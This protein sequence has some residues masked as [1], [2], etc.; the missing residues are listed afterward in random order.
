MAA[1]FE[2]QLDSLGTCNSAIKRPKEIAYF[3]YDEKHQFRLDASSI[4]YY[5]PPPLG[6]D[7][8]KGFP[9][10]EKLDDTADDHLDSLLKTIA[11]HEQEIGSKIAA[12]VITWRGLMTKIMAVPYS[13]DSFEL[14]ATIFE[15]TIFI[16]EN[17]DYK[18]ASWEKQRQQR[19]RPGQPSQDVMSFWGYKFETLCLLPDTWDTVSRDFIENRENH[20][21]NNYAQ[22]CSVV[23]TSIGS[24]SMVIG[25]EV[26]AVWDKKPEDTNQ[27]IKWVELKTS[28]EIQSDR[29]SLAFE[30]K[31]M[32]FWIQ[33]FL[34]GVPKIIVGFRSRKGILQRIEE[35]DTASIPGNV[36]RS[37]RA[38]WDGKLC[39]NFAASFLDFLKNTITGGVWRIRRQENSTAVEVFRI[40]ET[41]YS[42]IISDEFL[43]WRSELAAKGN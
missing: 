15:G 3:S 25:G 29:D 28:V 16:E 21:V 18:L 39:I 37:G 19:P 4:R 42:K 5:Y 27:P 33:S 10:F 30:R 34:L 11:A 1:K 13:R 6:A 31:L 35:F 41:G 38:T 7:L 32:K 8:S 9:T 24:T 23:Q 36:R 14:N 22:Y 20:T 43:T 12:E 40:E 17:H 2:I 26:D